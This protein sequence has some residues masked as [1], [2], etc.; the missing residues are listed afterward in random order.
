MEARLV[1]ILVTGYNGQLGYDI[2]KRLES[3]SIECRGVDIED[4]DLTDEKAV[5]VYMTSYAPDQVIHC[6]AYTAVDRAEEDP[7]ACYRVNVLGTAH[8]ARYC[9]EQGIPMMYFSTDY[10]FDGSGNQ[11]FET[12]SPR[13][14]Q[15]QYGRTKSQGE[16][17]VTRVL[18]K[19]FIIRTS[20]VFGSNGNNFVKTML[21]LGNERTDLNVVN[22][23]YGSPTYTFDLAV[24]VSDMIMTEEYGVYHATN[25]GICTWYEFALKIIEMSG[26]S[27]R[28]HPVPS[29]EYP[30]KAVRP[31]NSRMSKRSLDLHGFHRMP[32]WEDA[33][34]RFLNHV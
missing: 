7:D 13:N 30:A 14:P 22:D 3:K 10:V 31:L 1:K 27:A 26:L 33:L 12:D 15:N 20:W 25:E 21:R 2:V 5:R 16:D 24:L 23:Q 19:Y 4:F 32:S 28:I 11:P 29:T 6:A 34:A 9:A 18:K 17:A 8:I